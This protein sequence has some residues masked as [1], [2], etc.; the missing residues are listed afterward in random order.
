MVTPPE[1]VQELPTQTVVVPLAVPLLAEIVTD[2]PLVRDTSVTIPVLLTVTAA[3][4]ELLQVVPFDAV[5]FFVL[6]SSNTPVAV[7]CSVWSRFCR[8]GVDGVIVMLDNVGSTKKPL[9]PTVVVIKNAKPQSS[10]NTPPTLSPDRWCGLNMADVRCQRPTTR[11]TG[12]LKSSGFAI[13][14]VMPLN[15]SPSSRK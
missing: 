15:M 13:Q 3:G 2:V 9:Q 8:A 11:L 5:T 10:A 14:T 12:L 4:S 1:A 6:P 7:N